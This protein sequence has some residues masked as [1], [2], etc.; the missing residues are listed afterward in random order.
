MRTLIDKER[1]VPK[2]KRAWCRPILP[3][4]PKRDRCCLE[5]KNPPQRPDPSIYSQEEEISRGGQP[6]WD[7]PD[8]DVQV[9]T[10]ANDNPYKKVAVKVRN[11]SNKA[12]ALG[13]RVCLSES[14]YFAI[15][16]IFLSQG[17][18]IID[19]LPGQECEVEYNIPHSRLTMGTIKVELIH[20]DDTNL[21]NNYGSNST[22]QLLTSN[23]G[24]DNRFHIPIENLTSDTSTISLSVVSGDLDVTIEPETLTLFP[25]DDIHTAEIFIKV[26]DTLHGSASAPLRRD[27]TVMAWY[28]DGSLMGGITCIIIIDD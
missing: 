24:R 5:I 23:E 4:S 21:I 14:P 9:V 15:G 10:P 18:Q 8:I 7:N 11:L 22:L 6:T 26:P 2:P 16:G 12:T 28:D 25:W 1:Q 27:I 20:P 3:L 19:I 17:E 13:T